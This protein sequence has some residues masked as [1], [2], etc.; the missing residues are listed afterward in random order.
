MEV[1]MVEDNNQMT[2]DDLDQ[3]INDNPPGNPPPEPADNSATADPQGTTDTGTSETT[4][5]TTNN[6][7]TTDPT[8]ESNNKANAA[9]AEMRIQNRKIT[10]AL[11]AVLQ[12]HGLDPAL[13]KNPEQLIKDAEDARL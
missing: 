7:A 4:E 13:A 1:I 5:G 12:Q 8:T 3:L 11:A 10:D 2:M 9:F 6:T